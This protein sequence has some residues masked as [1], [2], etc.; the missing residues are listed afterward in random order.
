MRVG[1]RR[2]AGW[3]SPPAGSRRSGAGSPASADLLAARIA[4]TETSLEI[5]D[6]ALRLADLGLRVEHAIALSRGLEGTARPEIRRVAEV[7]Q[8]A[9]GELGGALSLPAERILREDGADPSERLDGAAR[10][11][12]AAQESLGGGGLE[13]AE[14]ALAAAARLTREAEEIVA[15][16]RQAF[17]AQAATVE[18]R[19]AETERIERQLPDHDRILAAIRETFAASVLILR[20]D[21]PVYPGANGTL[22][23]NLEE[24]RVHVGLAHEKLDRAVAA[25]PLGRLLAAARLLQEVKEHQD[26]TLHRLREVT[27]RE[28]R[29]AKAV[30]DNRDLLAALEGR[31]REDRIAVAGD[32]RTMRPTV[33]AFE[34]G[35]RR[36]QEARRA[37][38]AAPGDPLAAED[39]LL[40]AQAV[41][42]DV[43]DRMAPGDRLLFAEAQKSATAADRQLAAAAKLARH[44]AA[45]GIPDSP[46]INHGLGAVESLSSALAAVSAA[47]SVPHGDWSALDIEADRI[48]ADGVRWA[49]TLQG[50]IAAG[51]KA[52]AAIS[53][54]AAAVREAGSWRG[55]YG[56]VVSGSPGSDA[57]ATARTL[58]AEG[59]YGLAEQEAGSARREAANAIA[60]AEATVRR[61]RAEEERREE[62]RRRAASVAAARSFVSSSSGSSSGSGSSS[63]RSSNSR[64]GSSSYG[65]SSSGSGKSGW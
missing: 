18:E 37:V 30:A 58:L 24:S 20:A 7:V 40:A 8:A 36:V 4:E 32:P 39:G 21:D 29:L 2:S 60:E 14:A 9:R 52:A 55:G 61:Y 41:L 26:L 12:D 1:P 35:E 53:S 44:A 23:D 43:H 22:A 15:A 51:E 63:Y 46:E 11:A 10:Q 5:E 47:L 38:E 54:A 57:L 64:S 34:D 33:A 48:L 25:F 6:L 27:E 17:A 45:D 59:W 49:A 65:S 3:R 56:V 42:A 28:A 16:T 50:E 19:R 62:S 13:A 31:V